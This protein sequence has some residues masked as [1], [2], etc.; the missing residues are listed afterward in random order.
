MVESTFNTRI[1]MIKSVVNLIRTKTRLYFPLI[2]SLQTGLLLLTGFTGFISAKCPVINL[3]ILAGLIFTLF[4]TISGSTI[5]NMVYDCDID[6]KMQ[7]TA[8]R[9]LPAGQIT[10]QE[11]LWLGLILSILGL[12]WALYLS[13]IYAIVLFSGLFID[14]IIYTIWLKRKTAWSIVWGGISGGMPILAGRVLGV[15]EIDFIG[16]ILAVAIMLWIPTHIMTFNI[17]YINDYNKAKI[18]TF[19]ANYGFKNTRLLIA[20]SCLGAACAFVLGAIGLG[21]AWGYIRLLI[22]FTAG[23]IGVSFFSIYR[24]SEKINFG[25]F[26]FA[27]MYMMGTMLMIVIGMLKG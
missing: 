18:P 17:K 21:L 25:L 3:E 27:S 12:I 11:A 26:K 9:P 22:V 23:I 14:V 15:G 20:L 24:P 19:P 2:K 13:V 7:R 16:I 1:I 8:H 6:A 4:L 10:Y 5:L